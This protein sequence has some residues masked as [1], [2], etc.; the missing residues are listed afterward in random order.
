MRVCATIHGNLDDVL[1]IAARNDMAR[2]VGRLPNESHAQ[3]TAR[4]AALDASYKLDSAARADVMRAQ[5][6]ARLLPMLEHAA[7][8]SRTFRRQSYFSSEI[9][10]RP[11][12]VPAGRP[13]PR[14]GCAAAPKAWAN[15]SAAVA[16]RNMSAIRSMIRQWPRASS[17]ASSSQVSSAKPKADVS[18]AST[19]KHRYL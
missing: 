11:P 9:D 8:A 6:C 18:R 15:Y 10:C 12:G 16:S 2:A 7:S 13:C 17:H 1:D 19:T 4:S 5:G 14:E 3:W